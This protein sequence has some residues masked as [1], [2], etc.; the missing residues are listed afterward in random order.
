MTFELHLNST[1][2]AKYYFLSA[3][4]SEFIIAYG[5]GHPIQS[6]QFHWILKLLDSV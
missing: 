1:Q 6:C 3:G 5:Y 2:R 4:E